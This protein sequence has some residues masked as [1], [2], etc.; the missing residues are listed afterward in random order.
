MKNFLLIF[1]LTLF[2]SC[3]NEEEIP[4]CGCN[5]P[6]IN[7]IPNEDLTNVPI[8]EQKMGVIFFKDDDVPDPY[9]PEEEF[10]NRFWIF[11][12]TEGCTNCQ[13]KFII[14]NEAILGNQ[15]DFLKQENNN[16]SVAVSFSGDLKVM[17][18][19]QPIVVPGDYY[20]A[21]IV[22]TSIERTN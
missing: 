10:N 3:N 9:V 6:T 8:V 16:D 21:E 2:F 14:C 18:E 12:G 7:T 20:Y 5:S 22:L 13:R 4:S 19:D 11:Q 17:C 1:L 15:F